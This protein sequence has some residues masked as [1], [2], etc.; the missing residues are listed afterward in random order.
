NGATVFKAH[1]GDE[2][3]EIAR[4]EKIDLMTLDIHMPGKSGREVFE[5][6]RN[7][8]KLQ[9]VPIC[10]ITGRPELRS[11]IYDRPVPPPEGYMDKPVSEDNLVLN[12]K[13]ILKIRS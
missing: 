12:M 13:K 6:F 4:R 9:T 1:N 3:I 2:A 8:D 5:E 7:D 10:I 11:L